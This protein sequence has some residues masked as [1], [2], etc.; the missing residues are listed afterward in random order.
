MRPSLDV[1]GVQEVTFARSRVITMHDC[2]CDLTIFRRYYAHQGPVQP[3]SFGARQQLLYLKSSSA[4]IASVCRHAIS[5]NLCLLE[6]LFYR[7]S[8]KS[9]L[10]PEPLPPL[11]ATVFLP[12]TWH[13]VVTTGTQLEESS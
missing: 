4:N 11:M 5:L 9:N 6:R 2:D 7:C 12:F 13:S 1:W 10:R 8:V 3:P